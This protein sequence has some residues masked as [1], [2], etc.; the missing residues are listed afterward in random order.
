MMFFYKKHRH[1]KHKNKG[2]CVDMSGC[3]KTKKRFGL[4]ANE[5]DELILQMALKPKIPII[6][7]T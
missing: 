3:M 5:M 1:K 6:E 4:T 2:K 7:V